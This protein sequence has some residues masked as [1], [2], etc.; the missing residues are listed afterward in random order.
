MHVD[1]APP[2]KRTPRLPPPA[3]ALAATMSTSNSQLYRPTSRLQVTIER[4]KPPQWAYRLWKQNTRSAHSQLWSPHDPPSSTSASTHSR[5]TDAPLMN[6]TTMLKPPK[7]NPED[8]NTSN[9]RTILYK[10]RHENSRWVWVVR[11]VSEDETRRGR[12]GE[13]DEMKWRR[14]FYSTHPLGVGN[15]TWRYFTTLLYFTFYS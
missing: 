4:S 14:S 7:N 11:G 6:T 12:W 10:R 1:G 3:P 8:E 13:G 15:E 9:D 2:A 5:A